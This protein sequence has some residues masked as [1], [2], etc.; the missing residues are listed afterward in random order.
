MPIDLILNGVR[1]TADIDPRIPLLWAVREAFGL[2][3]TKYGCGIADA[4]TAQLAG[5]VFPNWAAPFVKSLAS[6]LRLPKPPSK[7]G[8]HAKRA[9]MV[10]YIV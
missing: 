10:A 8:T 5:S 1:R 7:P 9:H 6:S 4:L 3:G 2:T